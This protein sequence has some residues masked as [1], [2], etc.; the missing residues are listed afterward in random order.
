MRERIQAAL[1]RVDPKRYDAVLL[2]YGLCN[3]G[4]AGIIAGALPLVLPRAHD[5]ITLFMGSKERYLDYFQG[6]PGVYFKTTGWI[7][8]GDNPEELSQLSIPHRLGMD[9]DFAS[10]VAKYGEENAR[11]LCDVLCCPTRHYSQLT[12]IEMGVEPD[13]RFEQ[14]TRA[15]A[16]RRGWRFERVQ[17]DLSLLQRLVDGQWDGRDFLFVPPRQRIVATGGCGIVAAEAV[18]L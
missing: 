6:H 14:Q 2:G 1:D 4:L 7:E 3:T 5:C 9:A 18:T 13:D 11:Y 12:F 16:A 10:L 8:R 15:E 17:G